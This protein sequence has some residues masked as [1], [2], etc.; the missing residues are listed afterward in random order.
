MQRIV[1]YYF[2]FSLQ[3]SYILH[4]GVLHEDKV[5]IIILSYMYLKTNTGIHVHVY[6]L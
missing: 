2:T 3:E 6:V 4:T 1:H 5:S